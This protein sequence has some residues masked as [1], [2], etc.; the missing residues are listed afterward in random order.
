M[1]LYDRLLTV[2]PTKIMGPKVGASVSTELGDCAWSNL[3]V[4]LEA[5]HLGQQ[6]Q[7]ALLPLLAAAVK[8]A[9]PGLADGI[10]LVCST[11]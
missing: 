4:P 11:M 2:E 9:A 10:N 3:V 7:Q 5:V 8:A 1:D 6:L